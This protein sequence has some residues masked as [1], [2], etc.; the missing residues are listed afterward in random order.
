MDEGPDED[1][2]GREVDESQNLQEVQEV[3]VESNPR[4]TAMD[5]NP[6]IVDDREIVDTPIAEVT[7]DGH[8]EVEAMLDSGA[9]A[10]VCSPHDF[11]SVAIDTES[12]VTKT[13]R[14]ADGRELKVYG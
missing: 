5:V 12:D 8:Y 13:Y 14:C 1:S 10:S 6:I 3:G 4:A 2:H 11:P 7:A 9:G